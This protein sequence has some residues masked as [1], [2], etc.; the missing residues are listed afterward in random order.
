MKQIIFAAS[1][2][3]L[4]P[5][6][7]QAQFSIGLKAGIA[8]P[9]GEYSDINIENG[10]NDFDLGV[11][12][13]KFGTQFGA[14]MRFGRRFYL[15]PEVSLHSNRTDFRVGQEGNDDL[16]KVERY[17]HLTAPLL[18]GAKLGPFRFHAGPVANYYLD[19]DSE[20]EEIPGYEA[21][22]KKMS[23][24][25]LGGVTVGNGRFSLDIRYQGNFTRFGNHITFFGEDYAFSQ[26]PAQIAVGLNWALIK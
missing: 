6:V 26:R 13:V 9:L 15:Q 4:F 1:L 22:W 21:D 3:L 14:Y 19:S 11:E 10:V 17:R 23:L 8:S 2:F 24:G 7:S 18:L 20:L 25:W 16:I 5:F 12:D